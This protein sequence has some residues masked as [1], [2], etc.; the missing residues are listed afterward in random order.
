MYRVMFFF[1]EGNID[2]FAS[3]SLHQCLSTDYASHLRSLA[4]TMGL[5]RDLHIHQC[6]A[7]TRIKMASGAKTGSNATLVQTS[8]GVL[9]NNLSSIIK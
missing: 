2:K 4:V 9:L 5:Q 8:N 7:T 6:F 3:C 1:S